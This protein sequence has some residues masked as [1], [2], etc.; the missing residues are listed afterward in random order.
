MSDFETYH[1]VGLPSWLNTGEGDLVCKSL[2]KIEDAFVDRA[3]LGRL[4]AFPEYAPDDAL[5]LLGRQRGIVRG[6][7]EPAEAYAAR[8]IRYLDYHRVQG[9]PYA[10]HAQLRAYLQADVPIRTVDRAGNWF[11]T[12][13][14]GTK[15][16]LIAQANWSWDALP[17]SQWSR[18]WVVI[19]AFDGVPFSVSTAGSWP[20][21][22]TIGTSATPEQVATVRGIVRD[23]KPAGT[24]CEWIIIAFDPLSFN[25]AAP[26]P[27]GTWANFGTDV[28]GGAYVPARRA[29]ARYWRGVDGT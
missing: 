19:Y 28:G 3:R 1:K 15:S 11:T 23:W 16:A 24:T 9:N 4:A 13:Y 5:A 8:L 21:G 22:G 25:P 18:F 26:E 20:T 14:D 10:L 29:T 7:A 17:A 27:D 12:D 6:I 2:G